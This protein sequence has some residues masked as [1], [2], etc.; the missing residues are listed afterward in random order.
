MRESTRL[1]ATLADLVTPPPG[2]RTLAGLTNNINVGIGY[3]AGRNSD[4]AELA[5]LAD[6]MVQDDDWRDMLEDKVLAPLASQM[7]ERKAII[8]RKAAATKP[9]AVA[10]FS[11]G[12]GNTWVGR[13]KRPQWL[14]DAL[15][16][17]K[18]LSDF[19]IK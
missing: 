12:Q 13:G 11:D 2:P 4:H 17:G 7:A 15:A 18:Q 9:P 6:A 19:A 14:R 16:A 5:A 3:V 10:K 8:A 1:M